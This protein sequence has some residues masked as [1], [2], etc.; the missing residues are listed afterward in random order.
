M[1][2]VTAAEISKL[3]NDVKDGVDKSCFGPM[4]QYPDMKDISKRQVNQ[5]ALGVFTVVLTQVLRKEKQ[6]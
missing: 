6:D 2:K 1:I 3:I 4:F 5:L